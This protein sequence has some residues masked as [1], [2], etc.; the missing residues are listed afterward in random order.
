MRTL[1]FLS[2]LFF[3]CQ[4]NGKQQPQ[5]AA[6]KNKRTQKPSHNRVPGQRVI[7]VYVALCD[8]K[9]QG[10]VPVPEKI[11]N[12]QDPANNLYWGCSYGI[13]T[14]FT[15]SKEWELQ[16]TVTSNTEKPILERCVFKHRF[17]DTWLVA[18][19]YDGQFIKTCTETFLSA[20]SGSNSDAVVLKN[21]NKIFAAGA[22]HLLA[23]IGH[24]GL[25]DFRINTEFPASD[26]LQREAIILAC[27]SKSYFAPKL[28]QTAAWPILWSTG[29]MAPEAYVL[30]DA[31]SAWVKNQPAETVRS[32]AA[33]AYSKY[34]KC[35][36]KA[37]RNLL[38]TGW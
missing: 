38:V 32:N 22:S 37:A 10:I 19:A 9:Y 36:M 25:M 5:Q 6:A 31:L 2:I 27:I 23:Y 20:C 30:H 4:S 7:H 21:G 33:A 26:Q 3:S 34:Q 16:K 13:K 11:G 29:L 12:G 28:K 14:F 35:S 15:K 1:L 8:N 18:D 24:D 17:S